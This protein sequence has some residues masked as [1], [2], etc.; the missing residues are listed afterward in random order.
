VQFAKRADG[1]HREIRWGPAAGRADCAPSVGS[2]AI[3]RVDGVASVN[4]P[5][6]KKSKR[7][8]CRPRTVFMKSL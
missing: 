8:R 6:A 3:L 7:I 1:Q 2:R 4:G 5:A